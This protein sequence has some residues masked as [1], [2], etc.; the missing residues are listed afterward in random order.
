MFGHFAMYTELRR[1]FSP[2]TKLPEEIKSEWK[3][4]KLKAETG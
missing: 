1:S 4:D 3:P 2:N